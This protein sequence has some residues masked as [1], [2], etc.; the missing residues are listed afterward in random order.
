MSV[1]FVFPGQGSQY[2]G[3]GKD[4]YRQ[5]PEVRELFEEASHVL[6][7]DV[8]KLC[9]EGPKE[10]LNQTMYTQPVLLTV[11]LGAALALNVKSDKGIAPAV[12]AGHSLGEYSALVY[13]GALSFADAVRLV[14]LR[15]KYMQ[16]EAPPGTGGMVA[17]LGLD[18]LTVNDICVRV[19]GAGHTVEAVNYNC[20]GQVVI[21]GTQEGLQAAGDLAKEAG[22]RRCVPLAVS[23]P[24]H[25]SLMRPASER[26]AH[27][28]EQVTIKDLNIP[29]VSNVTGDYVRTAPQV[30]EELVKQVYSPVRW[31][32]SIGRMHKDGCDTFIE[33]GPGK[34]LSGLIK[35]TVK[36][37]LVFNV[38]DIGSLEK[39]LAQLKEVG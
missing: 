18:R 26:L 16:Q 24:F 23:G 29:V 11:S 2:V 34:V 17:L 28:I 36:G 6:N 27:D 15:G 25:S 3:M 9:F 19:S 20:P 13:A 38:E 10:Q 21:A 14:H 12:A 30:K 32:D 4:L 39:V 5:Y 37:A 22:A 35:K 7:F 8:A 33:L 1:A 31:E